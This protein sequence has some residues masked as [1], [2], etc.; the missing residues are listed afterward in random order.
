MDKPL[1]EE[2]ILNVIHRLKPEEPQQVLDFARA[3]LGSMIR[4][5]M[6]R[7]MRV[8]VEPAQQI[9]PE[10]NSLSC[11]ADDDNCTPVAIVQ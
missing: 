5:P 3:L 1:L 2:E 10:A 8:R 9:Q 7:P 11:C 6:T 4:P